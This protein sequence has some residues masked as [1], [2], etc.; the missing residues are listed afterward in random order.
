MDSVDASQPPPLDGASKRS[1]DEHSDIRG[2]HRN[3]S[4]FEITA[5]ERLSM[6]K[7]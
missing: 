5:F 3:A 4:T 7:I 6:P 1:P 2:F